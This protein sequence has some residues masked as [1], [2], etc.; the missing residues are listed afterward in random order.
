MACTIQNQNL[1]DISPL[2]VQNEGNRT[3]I[4]N[5]VQLVGGFNYIPIHNLEVDY[6]TLQGEPDGEVTYTCRVESANVEH[7]TTFT[8]I[9]KCSI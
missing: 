4:F 5:F 8:A 6:A 1:S 9:G 7:E 3:V 2:L